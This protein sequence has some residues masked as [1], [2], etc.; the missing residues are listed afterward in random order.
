MAQGIIDLEY[1]LKSYV[2]TMSTSSSTSLSSDA[3]SAM[4][5]IRCP[6]CL[7]KFKDP[8]RLDCEHTYCRDCLQV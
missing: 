3:N 4:Q 2:T 7:M 8:R 5:N 1:E 6:V